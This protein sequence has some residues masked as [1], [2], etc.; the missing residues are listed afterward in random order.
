MTEMPKRIVAIE[1]MGQRHWTEGEYM[2]A[3]PGI[4]HA[5][6][7]RADIADWLYELL[8]EIVALDAVDGDWLHA[9]HVPEFKGSIE[10]A[11]RNYPSKAQEERRRAAQEEA[12]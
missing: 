3:M 6:Y 4:S 9:D 12:K 2:P 10:Y 7:V 11:L 5:V 8:A 1:G